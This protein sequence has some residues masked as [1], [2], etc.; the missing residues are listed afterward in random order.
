MTAALLQEYIN[1][2]LMVKCKI[3]FKKFGLLKSKIH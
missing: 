3:N 2:R 1:I